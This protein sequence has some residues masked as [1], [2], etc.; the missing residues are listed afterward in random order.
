M[1]GFF[2]FFGLKKHR[3]HRCAGSVIQTDAVRGAGGLCANVSEA[4]PPLTRFRYRNLNPEGPLRLQ[5]FKEHPGI[6]GEDV[7]FLQVKE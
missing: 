1:V 4:T 7:V 2:V 5:T 6:L 3:H